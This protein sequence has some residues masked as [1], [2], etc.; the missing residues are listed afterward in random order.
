MDNEADVFDQPCFVL[1]LELAVRYEVRL[2][3]G[4][5]ER[6]CIN[7]EPFDTGIGDDAS[8]SVE[9]L[10]ISIE[11][12]LGSSRYSR[13]MTK[14]DSLQRAEFSALSLSSSSIERRT[15]PPFEC[16]LSMTFLT[17]HLLTPRSFEIDRSD[18]LD[19]M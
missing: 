17:N 6:K 1:G 19:Q 13:K 9:R 3:K 10:L 7:E 11:I 8:V 4:S 16:S 18:E 14:D 12:M 15:L 2:T 5:P